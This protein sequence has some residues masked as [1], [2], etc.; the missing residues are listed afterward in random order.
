M[1]LAFWELGLVSGFVIAAAIAAG[2]GFNP[3]SDLGSSGPGD[4]M[5]LGRLARDCVGLGS[6]KRERSQ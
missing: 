6:T 2:H 1:S 4:W 5:W 3:D